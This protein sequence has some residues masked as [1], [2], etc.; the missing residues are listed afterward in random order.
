M[1][2]PEPRPLN[3]GEQRAR[4]RRAIR[5]ARQFGFVGRVEY[6]HVYSQSGGAQYGRGSSQE[7]DLLTI[8]AEAFDRDADPDDFSLESMIAHE[9][10]HQ[11]LA[12]HPCIAKRVEGVSEASEE[13]L[14]SLLGAMFCKANDDRDILIAKATAGLLD[15]GQSA[16]S[17]NRQIQALW[18]LLKALL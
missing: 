3:P 10:G 5:I 12:R 18:D 2:T 1:P 13:I 17:A 9:C 11:I 15:R 14:A 7:A 16:E 4:R 6:R 8:Y